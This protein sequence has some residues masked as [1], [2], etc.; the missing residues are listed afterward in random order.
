MQKVIYSSRQQAQF[1]QLQSEIDNLLHEM[2]TLKQQRFSSAETERLNLTR[3][4]LSALDLSTLD[5][6]SN[7]LVFAQA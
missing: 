5:L 4:D 2:M 1:E 7:S 6:T 3:L